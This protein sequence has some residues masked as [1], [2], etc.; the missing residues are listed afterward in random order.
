MA[1]GWISAAIAVVGGAMEGSGSGKLTGMV[2]E[3]EYKGILA[4][5][6]SQ[7]RMH[8]LDKAFELYLS[9]RRTVA[10]GQAY[11][12]IAGPTPDFW[13]GVSDILG[14]GGVAS[15]FGGIQQSGGITQGE[16][17][18]PVDNL[19]AYVGGASIDPYNRPTEASTN[20]Q[21]PLYN[22]RNTLGLDTRQGYTGENDTQTTRANFAGAGRPA[23]RG[24]SLLFPGGGGG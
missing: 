11:G 16:R 12:G 14:E 18:N 20:Y 13:F 9:N 2:A 1:A 4:Q 21:N 8:S 10:G 22:I 23:P 19:D 24:N 17:T 7:E 15:L 3:L 6:E 5:I